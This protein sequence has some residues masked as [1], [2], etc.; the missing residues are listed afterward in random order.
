MSWSKILSLTLIPNHTGGGD[1]CLSGGG[2]DDDGGGGDG[3]DGWGLWVGDYEACD[4]VLGVHS[5]SAED[6]LQ[7]PED[8]GS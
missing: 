8:H 1:V 2:D 6:L 4:V 7:T 3:A 5:G